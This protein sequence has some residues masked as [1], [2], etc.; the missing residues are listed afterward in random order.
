MLNMFRFLFNPK[1][2]KKYSYTNEAVTEGTDIKQDV[3]P[4]IKEELNKLKY[5]KPLTIDDLQK[6]ANVYFNT[7]LPNSDTVYFNKELVNTIVLHFTTAKGVYIKD[8][9]VDVIVTLTDISQ[10]IHLQVD[11]SIK[12]L[13]EYFTPIQL[14]TSRSSKEI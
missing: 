4:S 5:S 9:L 1:K 7:Q 14:S 11:I 8:E 12:N 3:F 6:I 10:G 2:I 13:F